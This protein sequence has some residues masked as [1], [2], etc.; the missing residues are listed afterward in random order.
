MFN[1]NRTIEETY[2]G[3]TKERVTNMIK[4]VEIES[5]VTSSD[6]RALHI[7]K[8]EQHSVKIKSILNRLS[9]PEAAKYRVKYLLRH[10]TEV[11]IEEYFISATKNFRTLL[12]TNPMKNEVK[13][14]GI[15][16]MNIISCE[17][18]I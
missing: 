9:K 4:G 11:V 10:T 14:I 8:I 17:E 12:F 7:Y 13:S 5:Y 6:H 3:G 15:P 18:I 2:M 1:R 16:I